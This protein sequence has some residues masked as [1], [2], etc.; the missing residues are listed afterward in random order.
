VDTIENLQQLRKSHGAPS[1][2]ALKKPLGRLDKHCRDFIAR[3]P[4]LVIALADPSG[5]CDASPKGDASGFV[6]V[7]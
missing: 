3:S 6:Q 7:I 2:R 1:A 4:F 5:R